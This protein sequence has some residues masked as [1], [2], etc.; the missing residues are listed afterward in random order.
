M[1]QSA[2]VFATMVHAGL[3]PSCGVIEPPGDT[4][5]AADA[6]PDPVDAYAGPVSSLSGTVWAPGQAPG[7]VPAGHEIPVF[8]ALISLSRDRLAPIPQ[9]AYCERCTDPIGSHVFSDHQGHFVIDDLLPGAYWLTVQKGQFRSERQIVVE[10]GAMQVAPASTT[11]LPSRHAPQSGDWIPRIALALGSFDHLEDILGKMQL[12]AVDETGRFVPSSAIGAMDVYT[13]GTSFEGTTAG[14]LDDLVGNR[15]QLLQYHILFIP[16][17]DESN[18]HALNDQQNLRNIREFVDAGGKLYVT[19]WSGEWQDNVFPAQ[20][21]L[22]GGVDTP[23]SAY[24]ADTNSWNTGLFGSADGSSYDST[25]AEIVDDD[26]HLWLATQ[27]GPI[28]E[29]Y[30]ATENYDPGHFTVEGNWNQIEALDEVYL[31]VN[32]EGMAVYDVPKTYIVGGAN[33]N[34]PKWPLT[35]T[36]EPTGCGRVLYS[37]YHT[38]NNTHNGLVPQERVLLYLIMEIGV[39]QSGPYIE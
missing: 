34:L 39:C 6:S 15:Q 14:S 18:T 23:A 21:T 36:Y 32:D 38:T 29:D 31:G 1:R 24:D 22:G 37:T 7:Q 11:T 8:D 10:A 5:S 28:V 4:T 13:N 27:S 9:Q 17:A 20:I 19:D 33:N 12:G 30:Q 25:N 35:V 2:L 3:A 26:L 16:C